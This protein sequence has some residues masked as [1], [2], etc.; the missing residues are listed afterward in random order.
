MAP[1]RNRAVS[2][3]FNKPSMNAASEHFNWLPVN[4]SNGAL[5]YNQDPPTQFSKSLNCFAV[6]CSI[7][8]NF[9][10]PKTTVGLW[11]NKQITT[12]AVPKTAMNENDGF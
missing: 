6:P 7:A 4:A 12:M 2:S 5:P 10:N 11:N 9:P 1:L 8:F 3:T